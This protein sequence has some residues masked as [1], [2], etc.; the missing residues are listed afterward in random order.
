MPAGSGSPLAP[1]DRFYVAAGLA[2]PS[3]EVVAASDVPVAM[4]HL[5]TAPGP[6]TPRLEDH[7]GPLALRVL[8]RRRNGDDYARRVVL[9]DDDAP[10][11]LGAIA[12][13]LARLPPAVRAA[14]LA[15]RQPFGHVVTTGMTKPSA[16]LR[17]APDA[18]LTA[19]LRLPADA[20][21]AWLY[22]RRRTVIDER[23]AVV[24]TIV[25]VLAPIPIRR[26]ECGATA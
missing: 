23:A 4:R 16:L 22:G 15:E 8:E 17:I 3:V 13:D 14:V 7:H 11:L 10:V 2:L 21:G 12:V 25:D 1:L 20:A 6:L 26:G 24:A 18:A 9:L 5:L 19:A